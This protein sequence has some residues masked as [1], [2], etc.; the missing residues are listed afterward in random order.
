MLGWDWR[1]SPGVEVVVRNKEQDAVR[2]FK[3]VVEDS[4]VVAL[5]DGLGRDSL[6]AS[7]CF[8]AMH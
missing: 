8:D 4:E 6:L 7:L 1:P 2:E 3:A 5:V